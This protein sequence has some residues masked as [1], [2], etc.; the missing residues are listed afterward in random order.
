LAAGD[1]SLFRES[2]MGF[3]FCLLQIKI[4]TCRLFAS[5]MMSTLMYTSA[6]LSHFAT[7]KTLLKW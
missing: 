1:G 4:S 5:A 6:S 3:Q 7:A 2:E